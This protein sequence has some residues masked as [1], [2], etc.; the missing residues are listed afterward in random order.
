LIEIEL[1]VN[2]ANAPYVVTKPFHSSQEM[3]GEFPDGS[4]L[5]RLKVHHN[6]EIERLILGFGSS[7]RVM[8]PRRLKQRIKRHTKEAYESYFEER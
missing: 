2:A 5:V 8:K 1:K 6:F 3:I 4:I 7:I